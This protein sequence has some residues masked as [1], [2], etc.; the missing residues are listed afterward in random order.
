MPKTRHRGARFFNELEKEEICS[1]HQLGILSPLGTR[2]S[3]RQGSIGLH[4][5]PL[6]LAACSRF[7]SRPAIL[8]NPRPHAAAP[9]D[10]PFFCVSY[11]SRFK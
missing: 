11:P 5:L 10:F 4:S 3:E 9:P 8:L 2:V 7:L 6:V 1:L